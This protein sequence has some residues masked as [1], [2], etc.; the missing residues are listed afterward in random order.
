ML[1][2]KKIL[3][4]LISAGMGGTEFNLVWGC[5]ST[6]PGLNYSFSWLVG[7]AEE[8]N[9]LLL[10]SSRSCFLGSASKPTWAAW[11]TARGH[12]HTGCLCAQCYEWAWRWCS[13]SGLRPKPWPLHPQGSFRVS[14]PLKWINSTFFRLWSPPSL[15]SILGLLCFHELMPWK[16]K[17]RLSWLA[18]YLATLAIGPITQELADGNKRLSCLF[19]VREGKLFTPVRRKPDMLLIGCPVILSVS[20]TNN[21][22]IYSS[23]SIRVIGILQGGSVVLPPF[24]QKWIEAWKDAYNIMT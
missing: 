3:P 1:E 4:K 12:S 5:F 20:G 7:P 14:L 24:F 6:S 8:K 10:G 21:S 11:V 2:K 18:R 23:S 19:R 16:Q 13:L 15:L 17:L 9:T 22:K